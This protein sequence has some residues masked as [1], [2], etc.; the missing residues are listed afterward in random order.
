MTL[1][2]FDTVEAAEAPNTAPAP[3]GHN[4]PP[5]DITIEALLDP[6][7]VMMNLEFEW[8]H[9][10]DRRKQ[11]LDDFEAF[12]AD[13]PNG[14]KTEE[15]QGRAADFGKQIKQLVADI[16][17]AHKA[18]KAPYWNCGLAVD[19]LKNRLVG[20]L[21]QAV[22]G[23]ERV[24]SAYTQFVVAERRRIANEEAAKRRAEAERAIEAAA[25][26]PTS[27][28]INN[29]DLAIHETRVAEA[30][31]SA[32]V[33]DLGRTRGTYGAVAS[34]RTTKEWKVSDRAAIPSEYWLLDEKKI[35]AAV[36]AGITVPGIEVTD[37]V[38]TQIR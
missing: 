3:I 9:F 28:L 10:I 38:K 23:I 36:K 34:A 2:L 14:I 22:A 35:N 15:A 16:D 12:K 27:D 33:A 19:A 21:S 37:V 30:A 25:A 32:P 17:K 24:M 1:N 6:D 31:A 4:M 26:A 11:L 5:S 20:D 7:V 8:E 18:A 29:A 13:T